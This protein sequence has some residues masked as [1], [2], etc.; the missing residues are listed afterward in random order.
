LA[1]SFISSR[2]LVGTGQLVIPDYAMPH[3]TGLQLANAIK[4]G[5]RIF[6]S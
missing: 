3:M 1:A 2:S 6:P 5:G 4:K